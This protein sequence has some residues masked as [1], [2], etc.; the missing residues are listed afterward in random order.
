MAASPGSALALLRMNAEIDVRGVLSAI[1]TPTLILHR[2][3][4]VLI[5]VEHGRYLAQ[6]IPGA[7]LV[8]FD[9][10]D[11]WPW[12]SDMPPIVEEIEEFLTGARRGPEP[13][14]ALAT[15][16]FTTSSGR[17]SARRSSA[18]TAGATC[19]NDTTRWSAMH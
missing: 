14:R 2:C 19:C 1:S 6:H 17:P 5:E 3:H 16:L 10:D 15:V 11:H 8:E 13:T 9:G 18:T 4:D 12:Y 7:R